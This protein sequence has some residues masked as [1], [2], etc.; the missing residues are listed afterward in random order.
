MS[1]HKDP[2]IT[3]K[4][5]GPRPHNTPDEEWRDV[6]GYE[7]MYL[8]SSLGRLYSVNRELFFRPSSNQR[9]Y[10]RTII[11]NKTS[12]YWDVRIHILVAIA[13]LGKC[14]KDKEVNHKNGIKTDNRSA[15][16]EY[17]THPRNVKHAYDTGL[18]KLVGG[19]HGKH[20]LTENDVRSIRRRQKYV[21]GK[22]FKFINKVAEE[23]KVTSTC[24]RSIVD[25]KTWP[26]VG[27]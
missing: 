15:N 11:G 13:F 19:E 10:L 12:G 20:K 1:V 9:G 2:A 22:M 16:L 24:I 3:G 7:R 14:P 18:R 8:V 27:V 6:P 4:L 23:Y 26:D 25:G 21:D 5:Y 17:V